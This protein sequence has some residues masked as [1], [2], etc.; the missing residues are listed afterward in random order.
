MGMINLNDAL[1]YVLRQHKKA[2]LWLTERNIR[3][4]CQRHCSILVL[5]TNT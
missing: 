2:R 5:T 1:Y 3:T 4:Y